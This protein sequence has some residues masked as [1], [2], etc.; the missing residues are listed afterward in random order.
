MRA[1]LLVAAFVTAFPSIARADVGPKPELTITVRNP[2]E[3]LYYLDLLVQGDMRFDNLGDTR[4]QYD[5]Q[6][7]SVLE[8][9]T[10][11]G[12]H[13][14]LAHGTNVPMWGRLTGTRQGSVV[15]HTFGYLGVPEDY[16]II[17]VTPDNR[18]AVS[19]EVHRNTYQSTV[20]YDYETG[21]V[22]ER[23]LG[24]SYLMQFLATFVPTLVI[25]GVTFL[26]FGFSLRSDWQALV[27]VNLVTK[28]LLTAVVGTALL[29]YGL[30]MGYLSFLPAELLVLVIEVAAFARL[31]K[32]HSSKRRAWFAVVANLASAAAGALLVWL[33]YAVER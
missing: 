6:K 2:P 23:N 28:V 9:Y 5:A 16:R 27:G 20:T 3:G 30:L 11:G 21:V 14:A 4:S 31:L 13:P 29:R 17:V 15:V 26:L 12:W 7:L 25:E 8:T 18:L 19:R 32:Q 10:E 1:L 22:A 24:L 33:E